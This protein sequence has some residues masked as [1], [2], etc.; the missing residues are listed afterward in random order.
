VKGIGQPRRPRRT[1]TENQKILG[2]VSKY[3][4]TGGGG[5]GT[6]FGLDGGNASNTGTPDYTVDGGSA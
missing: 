6:F 1:Q 5:G 4:G 2:N 3:I